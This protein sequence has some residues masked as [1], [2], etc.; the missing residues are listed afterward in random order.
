MVVHSL[1]TM[2]GDCDVIDF[3]NGKLSRKSKIQFKQI[4]D[5]HY[6]DQTCDTTLH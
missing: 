4:I 3:H 5:L 2:K 1:G 6:F